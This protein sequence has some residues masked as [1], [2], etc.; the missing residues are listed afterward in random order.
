MA[1]DIMTRNQ[2]KIK[3][4][5]EQPLIF[6]HGFGCDQNMWR[7]VSPA[8]EENFRVILFDFTGAGNSDITAYD[9]VKYSDLYGYAEDTLEIC[10][11]LDLKNPI[12]V[13]HSVGA[14]IG[15]LASIRKPEYFKDLI[16]IGASPCYINDLP[17]YVGGFE[18][19]DIEE[20]L[21]IMDQNFVQWAEVFAPIIMANGERPHLSGELK[22]S[23]CSMEPEIARQFARATFLSNHRNELPSVS[24]PS[25]ILQCS[26]DAIAPLEVGAYM[27]D[28]IQDSVLKIMDATGHCPH[29]SHPEET[30]SLISE[31]LELKGR[32]TVHGLF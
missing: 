27:H 32:V 19:E 11:A 1:K 15:M 12:Y 24:A 22:D 23:F 8:F 13:G 20:L 4:N 6:G 14:T 5:G 18:R 29:M 7:Y 31:Y 26:E 3:G 21:G 16:L 25:L 30:I 10:E 28:K 2:V 9:P 17:D